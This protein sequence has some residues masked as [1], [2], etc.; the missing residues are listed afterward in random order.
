MLRTTAGHVSNFLNTPLDRLAIAALVD[1]G[2][3]FRNYLTGRRYKRNTT[4]SYSNFLLILLQTAQE[5]GWEQ[6]DVPE[7]WKPI[8]AAMQGRRGCSGIVRYAI[9]QGKAPSEFCDDNLNAYCQALLNEGRHYLYPAEVRNRFR[10]GLLETGLA[11][12][13][14]GIC[15]TSQKSLAYGVPL[16]L[17]PQQLRNEVEALLKWKQDL[18]ASGRPR[19]GR[20]RAVSAEHLEKCISRLYGFVTKELKRNNVNSLVQL[21]AKEFVNPFINWSLNERRLNSVSFASNLGLLFAAMRWRYKSHDFSWFRILLSEIELEPESERQ[22]RKLSKYL[23]YEVLKSIP[24]VI[25]ARREEIVNPNGTQVALLVHDEL[26]LLFLVTLVWRQ[27][28]I[29]ECQIGRNLFK[30]EL[31]PLLNIAVPRW[32][33]ERLKINPHEQFWQFHF[34]EDETKTHHK[35]QS[36]LPRRLVPLLEEYLENYRPILLNDSDPTNLFLNRKGHSLT[37]CEVTT[38]VSSL[39]VRYGHRRVTPHLF[40]DIFAF[41]WLKHN[42]RDYLTLSKML[43]H[44]DIQTTIRIYGSRFDKSHALNQVE[45]YLD[46][47]GGEEPESL[48]PVAVEDFVDSGRETRSKLG[49]VQPPPVKVHSVFHKDGYATQPRLPLDD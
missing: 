27:R 43:W 6:P 22:D 29:R 32:V 23:P 46:R 3:R 9:R 47:L 21:V 1:L 30:E 15:C 4:R 13:F 14:P 12:Q 36:I 44:S 10:R 25:R 19:R 33:E 34:R 28:N 40:R 17:F 5:L 38:L 37:Q 20:H 35:V 18:H 49:R 45:E 42:P 26:L 39:T 11:G 8:L 48:P 2:P 7:E 31:P 16:H 41:W 24:A